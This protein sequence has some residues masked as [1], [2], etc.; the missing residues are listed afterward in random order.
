MIDDRP[1]NNIKY[2]TWNKVY[3]TSLKFQVTDKYPAEFF[4]FSFPVETQELLVIE[5]PLWHDSKWQNGLTKYRL[6]GD[7]INS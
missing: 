4:R 1:K 6:T 5:N 3:F 7:E 2:A